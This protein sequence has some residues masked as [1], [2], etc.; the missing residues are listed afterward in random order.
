MAPE[1]PM[2]LRGISAELRVERDAEREQCRRACAVPVADEAARVRPGG[3]DRLGQLLWLKCGQVTL[4]RNDIRS[5]L[6]YR[7]LGRGDGVVQRVAMALRC[8][9][10]EHAGTEAAGRCGGVLVGGDDG[11]DASPPGRP[12]RR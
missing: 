9:V 7:R 11:E 2:A 12:T 1:C 4:Q 10:D 6:A 3:R 8:G 5:L